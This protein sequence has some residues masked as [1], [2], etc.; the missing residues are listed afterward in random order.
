VGTSRTLISLDPLLVGEPSR[1]GS[2]FIVA[3]VPEERARGQLTL[4]VNWAQ[5]LD[6]P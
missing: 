1:D 6:Q 5:G 2:R 3:V 4:M